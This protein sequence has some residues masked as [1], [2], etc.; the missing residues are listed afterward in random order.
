MRRL[1][2]TLIVFQKKDNAVMGSGIVPLTTLPLFLT[3]C[4]ACRT[5]IAKKS[6][7]DARHA[8][9]PAYDMGNP[10]KNAWADEFIGRCGSG[11]HSVFHPLM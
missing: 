2:Y 9:N 6:L 5:V 8:N 3:R 7:N 11:L 10:V 1:N 4:Q